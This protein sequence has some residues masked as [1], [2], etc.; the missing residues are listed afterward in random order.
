MN[1]PVTPPSTPL[2]PYK[3]TPLFSLGK[4]TT[5]YRK[6][7]IPKL[8]NGG[9]GSQ[10]ILAVELEEPSKPGFLAQAAAI[11]LAFIVLLILLQSET[12]P[13]GRFTIEKS[14]IGS[15]DY[16]GF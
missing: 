3:H 16:I 9:V 4:D 7:D 10:E 13:C 14:G 15:C 11:A 2:P 1:A 5:A 12:A 6:L 8:D